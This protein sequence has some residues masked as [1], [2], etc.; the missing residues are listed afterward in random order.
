MKDFV[1]EKQDGITPLK[2]EDKA[3]E[4]DRLR[5][6]EIREQMVLGPS[7]QFLAWRPKIT[8]KFRDR[9]IAG[10]SALGIQGIDTDTSLR[11]TSEKNRFTDEYTAEDL[12][13]TGEQLNRSRQKFRAGRA[14]GRLLRAL[15]SRRIYTGNIITTAL[16]HGGKIVKVDSDYLKMDKD[17]LARREADGLVTNLTVDEVVLMTPSADCPSVTMFA[18]DVNAIGLAHCGWKGLRAGIVSK[19]I[20]TICDE[21]G[22]NIS[23]LQVSVSPSAGELEYEVSE[24][25]YN[26]FVS[27]DPSFAK[28]FTETTLQAEEGKKKFLFKLLISDRAWLFIYRINADRG[29]KILFSII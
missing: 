15:S 9:I 1:S 12:E 25:V 5:E 8:K 14:L 17:E 6:Q 27:Q 24:D 22:A 16:V 28:A 11:I 20:K 10:T 26:E 13:K 7:G 2:T 4:L 18:P 29:W 3:A 19:L 23:E 21:Y